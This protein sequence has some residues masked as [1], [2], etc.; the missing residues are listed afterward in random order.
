MA[1][2]ARA[3]LVEREP[4]TSPGGSLQRSPG[5]GWTAPW[6]GLGM[7]ETSASLWDSCGPPTALTVQIQVQGTPL[8]AVVDM[9]AEVTV[10]C[11]EVYNRLQEKPSVRR[12]VTMLQ[13]GDG[14]SLKGFIAGPF[15][16]KA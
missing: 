12:R 2:K 6:P 7:K 16:V 13:A 11:T 1:A 8:E 3:E 4:R 14:A 5:A 10:P 15:D 9:G